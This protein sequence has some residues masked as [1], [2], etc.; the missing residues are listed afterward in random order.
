MVMSRNGKNHHDGSF[1][2]V[3]ALCDASINACLTLFTTLAGLAVTDLL[4]SP[5]GWVVAIIAAGGQFFTTLAV[6]RG[7][8]AKR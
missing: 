6:K 5:V 2:W 1:D 4:R 7:L 3:D 8:R